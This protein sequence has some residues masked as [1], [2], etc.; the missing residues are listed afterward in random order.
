MPN[1]KFAA[2]VMACRVPVPVGAGG[3]QLCHQIKSGAE[4]CDRSYH[5]S[6][7]GFYRLYRQEGRICRM[8]LRA[9][10]TAIAASKSEQTEADWSRPSR[11]GW[12]TFAT[13]HLCARAAR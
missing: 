6:L 8:E 13:N 5:I 1:F 10:T 7:A 11:S 4:E 12:T 9:C 2:S 3:H